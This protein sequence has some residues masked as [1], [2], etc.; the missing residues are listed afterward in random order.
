MRLISECGLYAGVYGMLFAARVTTLID[1]SNISF[2]Y[3]LMEVFLRVTNILVT[4]QENTVCIKKVICN[5]M[6][7]GAVLAAFHLLSVPT[8]FFTSLLKFFMPFFICR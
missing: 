8:S 2:N 5:V 3:F 1:M 7:P 4:C 6:L